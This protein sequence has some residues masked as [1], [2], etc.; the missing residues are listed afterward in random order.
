LDYAGYSE[1]GIEWPPYSPDLNPLDYFLWGY[2]KDRVYA[3]SPHTLE[4]L[5]GAIKTHI[6][7]IDREVL[8]PEICNF[9]LR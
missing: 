6:D 9:S 3:N 5:K 8:Q 2:L 4:E 1:E 7:S